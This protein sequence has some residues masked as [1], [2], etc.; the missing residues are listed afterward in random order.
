V[1]AATTY[2]RDW[3]RKMRILRHL[4]L[5][6]EFV[7]EYGGSGRYWKYLERIAHG[8]IVLNTDRDALSSLTAVVQ[9]L[10]PGIFTCPRVQDGFLLADR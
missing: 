6:S 2:L 1:V 9:S 4:I 5:C 3:V 7:F 8:D 10:F